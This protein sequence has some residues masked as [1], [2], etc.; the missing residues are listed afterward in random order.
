MSVIIFNYQYDNMQSRILSGLNFTRDISE[1][2]FRFTDVEPDS[3]RLKFFPEKS[4]TEFRFTDVEPDSV[5]LKFF[6]EKSETEFRFTNDKDLNLYNS[7]ANL[8]ANHIDL[9]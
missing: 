2:E 8:P 4:E 6:P 9:L 3:V 7:K 1:T 5:R